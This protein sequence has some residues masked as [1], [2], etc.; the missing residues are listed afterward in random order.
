MSLD[1]AGTS[2][3]GEAGGDGV[4]VLAEEAGKAPHRLRG[5]LLGLPDPL[6][7]QV[8]TPR[9]GQVGE[10]VGEVAGSGDVRAGEPE[11]RW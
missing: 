4:E 9:T 11:V 8:S 2:R 6:Q 1:D 10:G 3:Q 5:V 7:Q